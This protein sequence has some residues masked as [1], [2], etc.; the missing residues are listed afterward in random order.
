MTDTPDTEAVKR[1]AFAMCREENPCTSMTHEIMDMPDYRKGREGDAG[2]MTLAGR[3]RSLARAALAAM[4][5]KVTV[6]RVQWCADGS[7]DEVAVRGGAH[8]EAMSDDSW[9]L[10]MMR[11]DGS[12]FCVWFSGKVTMTEER[13]ALT[14]EGSKP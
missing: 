8:L 6:E 13:P 3:Y 9:F 7:L 2:A 11:C 10:S 14:P 4:P 12:E 1:L 5:P